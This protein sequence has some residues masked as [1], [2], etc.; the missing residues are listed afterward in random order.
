MGNEHQ[1]ISIG[2]KSE[3]FDLCKECYDKYELNEIDEERLEVKV[4]NYHKIHKTKLTAKQSADIFLSYVNERDRYNELIKYPLPEFFIGPFACN[5]N[6][7]FYVKEYPKNNFET[8]DIG[9][10]E[11]LKSAIQSQNE[12]SCCCFT[13]DD[14]TKIEFAKS[15]FMGS[16]AGL[17]KIYYSYNIRL[18]DES[19]VTYKP[20][21][22]K[23][24]VWGYGFGLGHRTSAEKSLVKQLT[25]FKDAIGL[26][27]PIVKVKKI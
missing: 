8:K 16:P 18:N 9:H 14:V 21:I 27:V 7:Y 1:W 12:A 3:G 4:G 26:D 10:K 2:P 17:F 13:K 20:C 6:G 11:M 23:I 19:E 24:T 25:E 5:R 22:T 15:S